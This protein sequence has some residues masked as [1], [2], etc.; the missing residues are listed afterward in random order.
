LPPQRITLVEKAGPGLAG[1]IP[2]EILTSDFVDPR[3]LRYVV[4]PQDS[5]NYQG[6]IFLL[7]DDLCYSAAEGFTAFC[8]A[9]DFATVVGT[10]TGGDGIAFTP[11]LVTLPNSGLVVRFPS[12]MGLNPN[13]SANEETHTSPD[14]MV[15]QSLDDI[16]EYLANQDSASDNRPDP[17]CDAGLRMCLAL[18]LE[19][20]TE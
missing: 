9:S 10:W 13:F 8:E 4:S 16:L 18:A 1:S 17:S 14:V 12:V 20:A 19:E 6:R 15:E 3:V 7:V 5:I 11:A 2:P